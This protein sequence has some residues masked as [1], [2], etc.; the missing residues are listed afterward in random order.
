MHSVLAVS[1][2]QRNLTHKPTLGRPADGVSTYL[3][4]TFGTLLSSQGTEA[5]F[6]PFPALRAFP[7]MSPTLSDP[8]GSEFPAGVPPTWYARI[9]GALGEAA[10]QTYWTVGEAGKSAAQAASCGSLRWYRM[11]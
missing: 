5:S 11:T 6:E 3:A 8:L 1:I 9:P 10:A 7:S 4:L 2:I